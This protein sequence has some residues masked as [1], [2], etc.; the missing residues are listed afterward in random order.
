MIPLVEGFMREEYQNY[1]H[2]L[3]PVW[4]GIRAI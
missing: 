4:D 2:N 1:D 3:L